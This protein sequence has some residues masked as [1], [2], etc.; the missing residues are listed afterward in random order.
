M[1]RRLRVAARGHGALLGAPRLPPRG[2][3]HRRLHRPRSTSTPVSFGETGREGDGSGGG[4]V[5]D[6]YGGRSLE[7]DLRGPRRC[8]GDGP[9]R[10]HDGRTLAGFAPEL[11]RAG[12][13]ALGRQRTDQLGVARNVSPAERNTPIPVRP[14]AA[15]PHGRGTQARRRLPDVPG[16]GAPRRHRPLCD[17]RSRMPPDTAALAGARGRDRASPVATAAVLLADLLLGTRH[18][19]AALGGDLDAAARLPVRAGSR[20]QS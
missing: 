7:C 15:C 4:P 8:G 19:G 10:L 2:G 5:P 18:P 17:L 16:A 3:R 12:G 11:D 6:G 13:G 1:L 14:P 20:K 9:R